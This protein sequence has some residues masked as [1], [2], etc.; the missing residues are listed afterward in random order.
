MIMEITKNKKNQGLITLNI[1][2][3]SL[4]AQISELREINQ[5]RNVLEKKLQ[6]RGKILEKNRNVY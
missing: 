2:I 5:K 3:Q 1:L 4:K 6:S